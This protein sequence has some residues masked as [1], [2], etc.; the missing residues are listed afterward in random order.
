M[1]AEGFATLQTTL[2]SKVP[3]FHLSLPPN[4]SGCTTGGVQPR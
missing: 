1:M 2:V 3:C 4:G